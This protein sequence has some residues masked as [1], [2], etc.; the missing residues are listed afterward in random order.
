MA[1]TPIGYLTVG[2]I[3]I[4]FIMIPVAVGAIMVGPA[5]GAFLG[6]VFGATS[7]AQCF[8]LNVF[9]TTLLGINPIYTAILCFVPRILMGWL[10][11]LIFRALHKIDKTRIVSYMVASLSGAV[12]NTVLFMIGL[13]LLFGQTDYIK[14][15]MGVT[16]IALF[17]AILVNAI[18]E[19]GV[20]MIIGTAITKALSKVVEKRVPAATSK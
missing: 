18:V 15:G 4:T 12:L 9:G 19:A 7:F 6:L 10:V 16:I 5:S 13:S 17:A 8:G 3:Q 20:C 11:A 2:V 14:N 1:F